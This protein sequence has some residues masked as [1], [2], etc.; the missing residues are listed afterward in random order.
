MGYFYPE[1]YGPY[2]STNV[3]SHKNNLEPIPANLLK[4]FFRPFY[5][6]IVNFNTDCLPS[7]EPGLMLELGCAS[8]SYLHQMAR[9]GWQ[10]EGI[11]YSTKAAKNARKPGYKVHIGPLE[12]APAPDQLFDLIVGWMVLEHLHD[13]IACL[14]KLREWAKPDTWLVLSVPN[15]GSVE[16][17]IFKDKWYAL[18]LPN[19]LFHFTPRT[20]EKV[21]KGGGWDVKKIHHQ[22]TLSNLIASM[23]Y[24][25]CDAGFNRLGNK[26]VDF[27]GQPG[28]WHLFLYPLT[29]LLSK[30]GQTGRMTVWAKV[31]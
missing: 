6:K 21:L 16:F 31:R 23:G 11:E 10:V 13:P 17:T 29:W 18:Q 3:F 22:R 30:F 15:A 4:K 25:L 7:I 26:L 5:R 1:D 14:K 27:P 2:A 24:V 8:G 9:Q 12:T 20:L 19:H 28:R